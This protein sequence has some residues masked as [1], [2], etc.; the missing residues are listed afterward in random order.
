MLNT[1]TDGSQESISKLTRL[2]TLSSICVS[3]EVQLSIKTIFSDISKGEQLPHKSHPF[4]KD[5]NDLQYELHFFS[6]DANKD[7]CALYL[8]ISRDYLKKLKKSKRARVDNL[9]IEAMEVTAKIFL[10]DTQGTKHPEHTGLGE[11]IEQATENVPA[12]IQDLPGFI[13]SKQK[14]MTVTSFPHL[15]NHSKL[16]KFHECPQRNIV[17]QVM[18]KYFTQ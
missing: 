1:G 12:S 11:C 8:V 14:F 10:V 18:L 6:L 4:P 5:L 16:E 17:I 13:K 15:L 2:A 9:K 3:G 7:S